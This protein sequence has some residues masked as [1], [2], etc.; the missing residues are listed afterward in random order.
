MYNKR[1][2][3]IRL[4]LC[5]IW[6]WI[7]SVFVFAVVLLNYTCPSWFPELPRRHNKRRRWRGSARSWCWTSSP[8]GL[9]GTLSSTII[10]IQS[11]RRVTRVGINSIKRSVERV[12][13]GCSIGPGKRNN[14]PIQTVTDFL[15]VVSQATLNAKYDYSPQKCG[16]SVYSGE[17]VE[18][19][20]RNYWQQVNSG[21][22]A[23]FLKEWK[24]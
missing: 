2:A 6:I 5:H 18:D 21:E 19:V 13:A 15:W 23:S 3:W 12:E 22:C 16:S 7:R 17:D 1:R 9:S 4:C 8:I 14:S 10:L 11:Y 20:K 24:K